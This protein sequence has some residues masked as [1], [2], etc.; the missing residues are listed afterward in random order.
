ME[1]K[2][3]MMATASEA[4]HFLR[5]NPNSIDEEIFQYISSYISNESIKD[6]DVKFGMIA[7]AAE[8]SRIMRENPRLSDKE[9]LKKV[10]EKIPRLLEDMELAG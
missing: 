3:K 4:L 9:I 8:T 6:E 10:M 7:A 2:I 1:K 5:N